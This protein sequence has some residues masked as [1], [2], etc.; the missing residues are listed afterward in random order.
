MLFR[1]FVNAS[2]NIQSSNTFSDVLV[3]SIGMNSSEGQAGGEVAGL[4][5]KNFSVFR[6]KNF[7]T[8]PVFAINAY[9]ASFDKLHVT[10]SFSAST[11]YVFSLY[12]I[13]DWGLRDVSIEGT[14]AW[15]LFDATWNLG[16]AINADNIRYTQGVQGTATWSG[17]YPG[18]G[19]TQS[20]IVVRGS[21]LNQATVSSARGY[22]FE[23]IQGNVDLTNVAATGTFIFDAYGTVT[24]P[25]GA[26]TLRVDSSSGVWIRPIYTYADNAT[27]IAAGRTAGQVY[28]TSTG[29]LM[30]VY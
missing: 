21:N 18:S 16:Y 6:G 28:K 7:T 12:G 13:K 20:H 9:Q 5:L 29:N 27:A 2:I 15:D 1:S 30:V 23:N 14:N 10:D 26:V 17:S 25:N 3:R 8:T 24:D 19:D 11:W 22:W 4:T